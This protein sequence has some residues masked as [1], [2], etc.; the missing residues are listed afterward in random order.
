MLLGFKGSYSDSY[1]PVVRKKSIK[2]ELFR[3]GL[4]LAVLVCSHTF[5][6]I[7]FE[8]M[9]VVDALWLTMTSVTTVGYGDLSAQTLL[10][11]IS[12]TLL[13][14]IGGIA[15]LAQA[16]A[17]YFEYRHETIMRML[18]GDWSWKMENHIVFIGYPEFKGDEFYY[19]LISELRD[20]N[21]SIGEKPVV[22]VSHKLDNG[23]S[24]RIRD[25]DAVYVKK[26]ITS[27]E[28]LEASSIRNANTV[29][30][31]ARDKNDPL[32]DS[33]NFELI[34]RL[35]GLGVHG[36]FV[37]ECVSDANR[38]R[39]KK[40][41][42]DN[43][44]RPIRTYPEVMVRAITAP[45][46]EQVI[47]TLF[48]NMGEE[49]MKYKVDVKAEWHK[50]VETLVRANVG[51]PISYEKVDGSIVNNPPSEKVI[52][53]ASIFVIVKYEGAKSTSE[54]AKLVKKLEPDVEEAA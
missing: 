24:D 40:M 46:S 17:M 11:R 38:D 37:V 29:V 50:V 32:S 36:R 30:I 52:D 25:L 13:I 48:Y 20:T 53:A 39:L 2:L 21:A 19:K 33:I 45:G 10:G 5:A 1:S 3:F 54:V 16:M 15:L 47:E 22:I 51:I 35:R 42:A 14:Y 31:L 4:V 7:Y 9:S 12:T 34:D 28:G 44:I 41:G 23:L 8:K 49:C 6:M 43:I 27:E 18:R 26:S